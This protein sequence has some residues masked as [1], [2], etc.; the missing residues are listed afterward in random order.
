MKTAPELNAEAIEL[1]NSG[2]YDEA[3]VLFEKAITL[4]PGNALI[5][6]NLA[7]VHRKTGNQGKAVELL[8][9]V[10]ELDR[11]NADAWTEL[12]LAL[13]DAQ[14]YKGAE[15]CYRTAVEA[16]P[17]NA[18]AWNN[19]GVVRFVSGDYVKAREF[20]TRAVAI[21]SDYFDALFNLHDAC[22]ELG[23]E[24]GAEEAARRMNETRQH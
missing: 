8:R 17:K 10:V 23:D 13:Y 19:R 21:E 12:G 24:E 11:Q 6:F 15:D 5:L 4:D 7:V 14:D 1:T 20:F 9:K 2:Q 22:E 18:R 3:V 16:D